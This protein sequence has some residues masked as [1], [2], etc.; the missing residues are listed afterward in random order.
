MTTQP[1]PYDEN[2]VSVVYLTEH[3]SLLGCVDTFSIVP[4]DGVNNILPKDTSMPKA[5]SA[6]AAIAATAEPSAA[7]GKKRKAPSKTEI[8]PPTHKERLQDGVYDPCLPGGGKKTIEFKSLIHVDD[9]GLETWNAIVDD[10]A[11]ASSS[12]DPGLYHAVL[13]NNE[14]T[15]DWEDSGTDCTKKVIPHGVSLSS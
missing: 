1:F 9:N 13:V 5:P 2:R 11:S 4:A 6:D 12:A 3:N 10:F 14:K 8:A 15:G 7:N